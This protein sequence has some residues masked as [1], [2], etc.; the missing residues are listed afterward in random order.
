NPFNSDEY[1]VKI[2]HAL[3]SAHQLSGSYFLSYGNTIEAISG[4]GAGN[5][6][7]SQRA[8][9]WKQQ[10]YAVSDTWAVNS[11][12]VNELR[13]NY[14]RNFGGRQNLPGTSLADLGSKYT[15]QGP[16]SLPR[17][18]VNGFFTLGEAISGPIAGSNYYGLRDT[19]AL[20]RGRH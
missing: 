2:D 3:T 19:L 8:F 10:N 7:W 14:V 11:S 6:P 20:S 12:A 17:I 13:L 16:A 15:V 4:S 18:T 1:T 5:I 9:N